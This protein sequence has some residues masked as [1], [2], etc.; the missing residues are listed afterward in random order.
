M[1]MKIIR[2]P[3]QFQKEMQRLRR[4]GRTIGFVPTMGALHEGHLSLV[5]RA[6]KENKVVVVSIFV[7][8]LQFGPR[9]DFRRYP[10]P[11]AK[12][13]RLLLKEKVN[14]LFLPTQ[15]SLYPEG[16]Q[17]FVDLPELSRVL[18]GR[19]RPGH[20]R[21]V[22]TVVAKLFNLA[23][24]HRAYFGLKDYQQ[25][26]II[27][28]LAQDLDF[29]LEVRLLPTVRDRDGMA[30]SSR[31]AYL[32]LG[33]R[34]RAR[35]IPRA[36]RRA[37]IE[38]REGNRSLRKIR[39]EILKRLRPS[40]DKVDYVEFVHPETLQPVTSMRQGLVAV[41]AGWVGKT[42]LIDNAIIPSS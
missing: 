18:C 16:H 20:F 5:R 4:K 12:D 28:R 1:F 33:E 6:Q 9:E 34:E 22:A 3:R 17:T 32:S 39:L 26:K 27:Q 31:N 38:I 25:A 21:G 40:L 7:N 23:R 37:K 15:G 35:A 30:L 29:D 8:P 42:R 36:L 14:Y 2:S 13:R 19:F 24:P 41:A 11:L 10:R